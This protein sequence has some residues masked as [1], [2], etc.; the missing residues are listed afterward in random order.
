VQ[1]SFTTEDVQASGSS[2][3]L[4]RNSKLP[5]GP[6]QR[7]SLRAVRTPGTEERAVKLSYSKKCCPWLPHYVGSPPPSRRAI[8]PS[9]RAPLGFRACAEP[10]HCVPWSPAS[11]VG[12]RPHRPRPRRPIPTPLSA[13]PHTLM[14]LQ[15][16]LERGP[17]GRALRDPRAASWAARGLDARC[18]WGP[19]VGPTK[20]R[21]SFGWRLRTDLQNNTG[22]GKPRGLG[23]S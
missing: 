15:Q 3:R 7:R 5:A 19:W 22:W 21:K 17:P 12:P 14:I 23:L 1:L 2:S 18:V 8:P 20:G 6:A 11:H 4:P 10:H 13:R 16:P 9:S